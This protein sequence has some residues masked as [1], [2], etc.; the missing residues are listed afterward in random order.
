VTAN[1]LQVRLQGWGVLGLRSKKG[2][3]GRSVR[4]AVKGVLEERQKDSEGVGTPKEQQK[5]LSD[6]KVL[7]R[8]KVL[9][10]RSRGQCVCQS[11][12]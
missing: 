2:R 11:G 10:E 12:G 9:E 4:G 7:E 3:V 8:Q 5:V 1:W 6:R